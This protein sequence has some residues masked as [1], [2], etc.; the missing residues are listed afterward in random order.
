[1]MSLHQGF[2]PR[3]LQGVQ[4]EKL[5]L[6]IEKIRDRKQWKNLNVADCILVLLINVF[7]LREIL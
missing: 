3:I 1:M 6:L 4:P 2:V 7:Q 5:I